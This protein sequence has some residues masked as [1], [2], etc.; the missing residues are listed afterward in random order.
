MSLFKGFLVWRQYIWRQE[1]GRLIFS[2]QRFVP[3]RERR[4]AKGA[5]AYP[6]VVRLMERETGIEPA[7]SSLGSCQSPFG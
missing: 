3:R 2:M 4:R 1:S 6:D 7:T 5:P